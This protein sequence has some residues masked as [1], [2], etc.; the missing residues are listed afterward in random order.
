[1]NKLVIVTGASS[2]FGKDLSF[3]LSAK[4]YKVAILSRNQ[5]GLDT[6]DLPN[7]FK[8]AVDVRDR[9]GLS[10]A[11]EEAEKYFYLPVDCIINNAGIMPLGSMDSQNPQEWDEVIDINI[12]GVLNGIHAVYDKMIRRRMGTIIN[13]SSI[14][15]KK[16]F[17]NHAVYCATKFAVHALSDQ[18]RKEA[19]AHNI[20]VI[21]IAPGAAE[22][23]LL[24]STSSKDIV[25]GYESWKKTMG[26]ALDPQKVT[27]AI[28]F[29][30]EM[31]QEVCIREL[32]ISAINQG[33]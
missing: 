12:K 15:G 4:G 5:A 14:A 9:D 27:E 6:I 22:T 8:K 23:N 13:I 2:G 1:M 29:C 21:T 7:A 25:S 19:G 24:N 33:D 20:R 11:V 17:D 10:A 3:L 28:L 18:L 16:V 31:P 30:Y 32:V 26:G